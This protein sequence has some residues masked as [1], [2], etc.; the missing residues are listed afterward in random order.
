MSLKGSA[1]M[2]DSIERALW[3]RA[4]KE[5]VTF[6]NNLS[7]RSSLCCETPMDPAAPLAK[8]LF[9]KLEEEGGEKRKKEGLSDF[10]QA[11]LHVASGN[12]LRRKRHRPSL[13]FGSSEF[14][15]DG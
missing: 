13:C 15:E 7:F 2:H 1:L 14:G 9:L 5:F 8:P 11:R 12:A 10:R 4:L 3:P 6:K